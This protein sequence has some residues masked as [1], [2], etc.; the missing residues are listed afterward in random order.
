MRSECKYAHKCTY[1]RYIWGEMCD[2]TVNECF[3]EKEPFECDNICRERCDKYKP[4]HED[5]LE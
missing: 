1:K 3:A 4:L 5:K 2:I